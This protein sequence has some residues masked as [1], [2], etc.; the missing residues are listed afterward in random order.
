MGGN[1]HSDLLERLERIAAEAAQASGVEVVE[2]SVKG[3]SS[4]RLIR[5]DIDRVGP[6]SVDLADCQKFSSALGQSLDEID[7]VQ[8][9]FTLEVS[10]PGIDRPIVTADD[11]RRNTGRRIQVATN[12]PVAGRQD[13]RGVLVGMHENCLQMRDDEDNEIEIPMN[14]IGRASRDVPI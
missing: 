10:S 11:V 9:R 3:S 7:P 6:I 2:V 5:I 14:A 4:H 1:R 12:E 8:N 13:F